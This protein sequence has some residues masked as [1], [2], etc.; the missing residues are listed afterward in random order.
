M[1]CA[2]KIC[3][4]L[5]IDQNGISEIYFFDRKVIHREALLR[6]IVLRSEYL[7][8]IVPDIQ[9]CEYILQYDLQK[10]TEEDIIKDLLGVHNLSQHDVAIILRHSQGTVSRIKNK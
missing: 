3:N 10:K 7:M 6:G 8:I 1:T 4:M 9:N 2:R 5:D